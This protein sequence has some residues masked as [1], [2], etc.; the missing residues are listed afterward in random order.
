MMPII[1]IMHE[2]KGED[3]G[4]KEKTYRWKDIERGLNWAWGG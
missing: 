2:A 4:E 1:I 3:H